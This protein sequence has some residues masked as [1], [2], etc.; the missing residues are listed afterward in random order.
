MLALG[1]V[2]CGFYPQWVQTKD[3]EG[4]KWV[5][6]LLSSMILDI[7]SYWP[8]LKKKRKISSTV[9]MKNQLIL[10]TQSDFYWS[11]AIGPVLNSQT[12]A[13]WLSVRIICPS[14]TTQDTR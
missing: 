1:V 5:S 7:R 12:V 13:N 3:Y 11:G 4:E 8:E 9:A 10:L 2:D 14:Q 6:S